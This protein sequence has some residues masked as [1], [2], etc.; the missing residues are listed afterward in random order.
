MF[1]NRR[2]WRDASDDLVNLGLAGS[3]SGS[4]WVVVLG[5]LARQFCLADLLSM[6]V[7]IWRSHLYCSHLLLLG[8][9][10]L[11]YQV[12]SDP[13]GLDDYKPCMCR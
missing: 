11:G 8:G 9:Q 1:L 7:E 4:W 10:I 2:E 5:I 13:Q 6:Q 12:S 3:L